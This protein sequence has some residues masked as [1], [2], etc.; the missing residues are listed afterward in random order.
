MANRKK[1]KNTRSY[2][3]KKKKSANSLLSNIT[4]NR[5]TGLVLVAVFAFL[6]A[7]LIFSA[8]AATSSFEA[9]N[10]NLSSGLK[11]LSDNTA[12]N[13]QYIE[14]NAN[15]TTTSSNQRFPGDPNPRVTGKTYW[16]ATLSFQGQG[17][18]DPTDYFEKP[19]GKSLSIRR[20]FFGWGDRGDNGAMVKIAKD[21]IANNR[22]PFVSIKPPKTPNEHD[23]WDDM[24]NGVY[25]AQID[26]MLVALGK[27]PGPVWFAVQHEPENNVE[28]NKQFAADWR[29]MQKKIRERMD[30]LGS[31]VDNIA[32]TGVLMDWTFDSRSGRDPDDWWVDGIWDM[33]G[34]DPYCSIK[35]SNKGDTI[36]ENVGWQ[37]YVKYME[38]KNIPIVVAEWGHYGDSVSDASRIQ[39]VWDYT[40]EQNKDI[41]G[42]AYFN[43]NYNSPD[44]SWEIK[45]PVK[46]KYLDILKNDQRVMRINDLGSS[47]SIK[48]AN[49]FG[50]VKGEVTAPENGTYK[51][52]VRMKAADSNNNSVNVQIDNGIVNKVGGSKVSSSNWTW[53]SLASQNFSSGS[54]QVTL[55]GIQ[56]GV[57]VDRVILSN[58]TCVPEGTGDKC[59]TNPSEPPAPEPASD[60]SFISPS[61]NQKVSGTTRI[62]VKANFDIKEISYRPDNKWAATT[63]ST[64]YEWDTTK[65]TNGIH[66][67]VVRVRKTGDP[68][69]VY[70]EKSITVNVQNSTSTPTTTPEPT[71]DTISPSAPKNLTAS[72]KTNWAS[73]GYEM[74][75][76]WSA[77]S[78]NV[79]VT[80]YQVARNG[81]TL[82]TTKE[83]NFTDDKSL[84]SGQVYN[85]TVKAVD[86]AGNSSKDSSISL[87]TSCFLIWC[88]AKVL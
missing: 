33:H 16:G 73:F 49:D 55:S 12:S 86:A 54:K 40:F 61:N 59:A 19:T 35:C 23:S 48:P 76:N 32:F 46:D 26:E 36:I 63:S 25:D 88:S 72:L 84:S 24:G 82:G 22:L 67:F 14:F 43:S 3:S 13:G 64:T 9:E 29:S 41:V 70:T 18:V 87:Q 58:E 62:S 5:K 77:S 38:G 66:T 83:T 79:G 30:A 34:V 10:G 39:K 11:P 53:V 2:A 37:N 8:S 42:W 71:K 1:T 45:G 51:L 78:D 6:G 44:G 75:L 56:K 68:G 60:V 27:V 69:N 47:T 52:W 74:A 21:D 65:V 7:A 4:M 80:G 15:N 28:G 57:R 85:Y 31:K 17:I 20:T 81:E 50:T